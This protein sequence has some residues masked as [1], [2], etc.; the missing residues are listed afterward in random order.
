MRGSRDEIEVK[1]GELVSQNTQ[2]K[3]QAKANSRGR[4]FT[5]NIMAAQDQALFCSRERSIGSQ[6]IRLISAHRTVYYIR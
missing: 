3:G 5:L 6:W 1:Q 4:L 2:H